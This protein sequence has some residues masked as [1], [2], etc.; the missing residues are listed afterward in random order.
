MAEISREMNAKGATRLSARVDHEHRWPID[1]WDSPADR[2]MRATPIRRY[3]SRSACR[4]EVA[5][6]GPS[7]VLF[8]ITKQSHPFQYSEQ[9]ACEDHCKEPFGRAGLKLN[10]VV[11]TTLL[12]KIVGGEP[13]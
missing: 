3:I 4:L 7:V 12:I 5:V 13:Q 6:F 1:F 9:G 10:Q 11:A 2:V 8:L